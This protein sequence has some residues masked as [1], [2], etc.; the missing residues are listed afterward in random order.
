MYT[1]V[2][3]LRKKIVVQFILYNNNIDLCFL[4]LK[5]T[6]NYYNLILKEILELRN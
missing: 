5:V 2:V 1:Q 6:F 3:N 4:Y